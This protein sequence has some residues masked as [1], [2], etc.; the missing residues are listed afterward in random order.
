MIRQPRKGDLIT[1]ERA[2]ILIYATN[3]MTELTNTLSTIP[4]NTKTLNFVTQ[5]IFEV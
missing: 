3:K 1:M 5:F 2:F 4:R